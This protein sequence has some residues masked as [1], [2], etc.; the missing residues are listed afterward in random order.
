MA[1]E[2]ARRRKLK[3]Y[4]V[5]TLRLEV[6]LYDRLVEYADRENRSLNNAVVSLLQDKFSKEQGA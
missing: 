4:V 6:P 5:F 3:E 1:R 2:F